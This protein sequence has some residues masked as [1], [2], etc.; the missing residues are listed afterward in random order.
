MKNPKMAVDCF[1]VPTYP[2][3]LEQHHKTVVAIVAGLSSVL[4][5]FHVIFKRLT[6]R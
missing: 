3:V 4:Q 5:L 6:L 2:V 1:L